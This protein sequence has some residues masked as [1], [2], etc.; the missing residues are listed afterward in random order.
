[1]EIIERKPRSREHTRN[2][3]MVTA[4][5]IARREG[6]Q[7]VSIRKIADAIEYSAPIVYEYFDSKDILLNEIREEGFRHLHL[8]YDRIL[9]LYRDPEKRLYEISLIQWEFS[10]HHPEIYQ[11]MYNL[12]G[13]NCTMPVYQ[14][15][16]M[17]AV[18]DVVCETI[19][20]FIPKSKDSIQRLYFEWWS[21]S[22]GMIMLAMMLKD[23]Q[24][25]DKSAQIYCETMRRFVRGLR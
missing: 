22:H 15:D 6:W 24:P 20:S 3:I 17:Q 11:V 23:Q 10:R 8:E 25:M 21:V 13:A 2:G 12:D 18:T 19:F 7:A 16:E 14:S 4:K 5:D 9:K 1:M